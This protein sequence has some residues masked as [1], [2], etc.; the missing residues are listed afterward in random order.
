MTRT[1]LG[2]LNWGRWKLEFGEKP[3][4]TDILGVCKNSLNALLKMKT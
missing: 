1:H 2:Q 3:T 4:K